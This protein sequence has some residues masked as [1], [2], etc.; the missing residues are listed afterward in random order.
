MARV[1]RWTIDLHPGR[2]WL[3]PLSIAAGMV[4]VALTA[5]FVSLVTML[6]LDGYPATRGAVCFWAGMVVATRI[7]RWTDGR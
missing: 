7:W 5:V 6:A 3:W 4:G 2:R 1:T